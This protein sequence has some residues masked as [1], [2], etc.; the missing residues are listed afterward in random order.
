MHVIL[1]PLFIFSVAAA[2]L[3]ACDRGTDEAR[4]EQALRAMAAAVERSSGPEFM[5]Y[6][7]SAYQ[8]REGRDRPQL[9]RWLL[10]Q[11]LRR[12]SLLVGLSGIAIKV[13]GDNARSE[14]RVNLLGLQGI[15]P[16]A[17]G[18]YRLWLDWRKE[19]GDWRVYRAEWERAA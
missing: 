7:H 4:I 11:R 5:E 6:V 2:V 13:Q 12:Q 8:D 15:V 10:A 16:D 1:R 14:C 9:Q 3:P 18:R 17:H 19:D